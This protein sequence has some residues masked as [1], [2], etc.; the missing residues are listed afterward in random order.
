[1]TAGSIRN[2]KRVAAKHAWSVG[3]H[4]AEYYRGPRVNYAERKCS[5][6]ND[7]DT[8]G[9]A[10]SLSVRRQRRPRWCQSLL[11]ER[12]RGVATRNNVGDN[13]SQWHCYSVLPGT[14][15]LFRAKKAVSV[16]GGKNV[17]EHGHSASDLPI[18]RS[19]TTGVERDL[20]N[21]RFH[22]RAVLRRREFRAGLTHDFGG[23]RLD[24]ALVV[25]LNTALLKSV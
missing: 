14:L 23:E 15:L 25:V 21:R 9:P 24:I 12:G 2:S 6:R 22:E 3:R 16:F 17:G 19:L 1:M 5:M 18:R 20:R 10:R 4:L 11:E 8:E 7:A 13:P